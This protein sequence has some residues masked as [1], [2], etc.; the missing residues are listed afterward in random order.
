MWNLAA[1]GLDLD[2]GGLSS[3]A[4]TLGLSCRHLRHLLVTIVTFLD[5]QRHLLVT[6]VTIRAAQLYAMSLQVELRFI[7]EKR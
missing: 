4:S 1:K 3:W 7:D 6:I 5:T 2:L